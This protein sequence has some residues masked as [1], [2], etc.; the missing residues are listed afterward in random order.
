VAPLQGAGF[1]GAFTQGKLGL[2]PRLPWA[3][4]GC[5]FGAPSGLNF[6]EEL[7]FLPKTAFF[8]KILLLWVT[9]QSWQNQ[10]HLMNL[11]AETSRFV[12]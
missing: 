10:N 12:L 1:G 2:R 9:Y 4:L 3:V 8:R 5:P 6:R 7:E 11:A